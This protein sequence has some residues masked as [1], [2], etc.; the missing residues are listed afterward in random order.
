[1]DNQIYLDKANALE[2]DIKELEHFLYTV[3]EYDK[4]SSITPVTNVI[5]KKKINIEYSLLGSRFFG[6]GTH[7][8]EIKIPNE[9]R[10]VIIELARKRKEE[11]E[12]EFKAL[13]KKV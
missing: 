5:M 2:K 11:L 12:V 8:Q 3:V 10:N 6:C 7:K 13:F 9:L 4:N 1:M